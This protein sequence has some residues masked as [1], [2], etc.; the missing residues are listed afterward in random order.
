MDVTKIIVGKYEYDVK[1]FLDDSKAKIS[2][3]NYGA[4]TGFKAGINLGKHFQLNIGY[5]LGFDIGSKTKVTF[6]DDSESEEQDLNYSAKFSNPSNLS[7]GIRLFG[8]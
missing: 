6:T 8:F 4:L 3:T 1:D 2:S 5:K 7:F